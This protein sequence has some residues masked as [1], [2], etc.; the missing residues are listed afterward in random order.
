MKKTTQFMALAI[1]LFANIIVT[2]A[3]I[4]TWALT[5]ATTNTPSATSGTGWT[6][7]NQSIVLGGTIATDYAN[8]VLADGVTK[9]QRTKGSGLTNGA[10]PAAT[11]F[12]NYVEYNI[13][14]STGYNLSVNAI[15]MDLS[16]GGS[17]SNVRADIYYST[18]GFVTKTKL[19]A[20]L[21]SLQNNSSSPYVTSCSY[22]PSIT[23]L[24]NSSLQVR[25]YPSLTANSTSKYLASSNV[26]ITFTATPT[27]TTPTISKT[28]G[29]NPA[30]VM[31]S[32]ALTPVVFNY[33]NVADNANV[34]SSWY[35]DNTYTTTTTAPSGLSIDKNTTSKTVT[36]SGTP[37]LSTAKTYYYQLSINETSGNTIQGSVV[38]TPYVTPTPV[39]TVPSVANTQYV[40]AGEAIPNVNF[41]TSNCQGATVTGLPT[42]LSGNYTSGIYTIS[43][44][45]NAGVTPGDYPYTIKATPLAGYTGS[46][47]TVTDTISVRNADAARVLYLA[48]STNTPSQDLLLTQF[49][50]KLNYMVTKRAPINPS[51]TDYSAYD[52][53]VLHET[54]TGG[55][56]TTTTNEVNTIKSVDKPILNTK[57][58]F[59]T[60]LSTSSNRW[61]WGTPNSVGSPKGV[62]V[63][64]PSHP[65]FNGITYT[66]SLYIYNTATLKNIQ[67]TTA[68][69]IGGYNLAVG[70]TGAA[71]VAIHEVPGTIRLGAGKTSKYLLISLCT[72]KYN[73]LTA[74][75]LKLLDNAAQYLLSGTQFAAPSLNISSFVVN[76]VNA[77]IDNTANTINATLPIGTG[78]S[79]LQPAITL[80]GAGTSVSPVSGTITDFTNSATTAINYTVTDGINSK[81]YAAKIVEG[82]TG[83][84]QTK[85]S[86]IAFEGQTIMNSNHQSLR[87]YDTTGRLVMSSTQNINMSAEPKGIYIIQSQSGVFKIIK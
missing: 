61:G 75:G 10:L 21:L 77:S 6:A 60:Y 85:I 87:V 51:P 58:F 48:A 24:A 56:A 5:A 12:A 76:S 63:V 19:N 2:K 27:I 13:T 50:T 23:I 17:T 4:V 22:T 34:I 11:D 86:G 7:S 42:G 49:L 62:K 38:I 82:T 71:G 79:A 57:S 66:D 67:C 45:V 81:V 20:S 9:S 46:D 1:F 43:G 53:I 68:D 44:T 15:S 65:I 35:T 3:D 29:D 80:D 55:D 28:S 31:E 52:L 47:I 41:T 59:Y 69:K 84:S 54:L 72:G 39:L 33:I 32:Y 16:G 70:A 40:R 83:L 78:L 25:V 14:A 18:D 37:A 36:V 8:A 74:N 73:D 64:Q 26:K 30:T